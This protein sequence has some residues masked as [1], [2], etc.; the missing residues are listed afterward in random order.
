MTTESVS[1]LNGIV[2]GVSPIA[3]LPEP[4]VV[5]RAQR[6]RFS[7]AYKRRVVEEAELCTQPGQIGALLRREGLYSS[8]LATWRRQ[9]RQHGADGLAAKRTGRPQT[10]DEIIELRRLRA[11]NERLTKQLAQAELIIEVQKKVASLLGEP[12]P[13]DADWPLR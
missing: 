12:L 2:P 3:A 1:S 10:P 7:A 8:L 9:F 4:E 5:E 11:E 13:A 6:R